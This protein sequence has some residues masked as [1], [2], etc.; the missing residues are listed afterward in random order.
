MTFEKYTQEVTT[1]TTFVSHFCRDKHTDSDKFVRHI[2]I[3]YGERA[4]EP[5]ETMLCDECMQT[6]EYGIMRL[7]GCPFDEKP[8]CRKC[9]DP[10]YERP[11]W[12]RVAAIMR[13]SG[14]KLG[15][16]KIRK[17]IRFWSVER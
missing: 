12:K 11:M 14:M 3:C 6:I 13:Y 15:L 8:K 7:D 2:P 1:L 17:K 4:A 5:I 16:T 9:P 10:C